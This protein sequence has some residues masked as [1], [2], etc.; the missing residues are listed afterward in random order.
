MIIYIPSIPRILEMDLPAAAVMIDDRVPIAISMAHVGAH[1]SCQATEEGAT[2]TK[3]SCVYKTKKKNKNILHSMQ[4]RKRNLSSRDKNEVS[5][6]FCHVWTKLITVP[7]AP[8][9]CFGII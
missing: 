7:Y 2:K 4:I 8:Q 3:Q 1:C 9:N 5:C 6:L